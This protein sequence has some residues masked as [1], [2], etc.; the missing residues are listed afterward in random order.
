MY[1]LNLEEDTKSRDMLTD[2]HKPRFLAKINGS[3]LENKREDATGTSRVV[4][5]S[6][7]YA[8]H[9]KSRPPIA[10]VRPC[11]ATPW[12]PERICPDRNVSQPAQTCA[13]SPI[14]LNFLQ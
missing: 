3:F 12:R 14:T 8:A 2:G 10:Q 13:F 7:F 11:A 9:K 4:I 1:L 5:H 6:L